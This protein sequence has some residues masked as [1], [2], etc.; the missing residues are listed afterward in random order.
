MGNAAVALS[1]LGFAVGMVFRFW[2]LLPILALLLLVSLVFSLVS[3]F[4]FFDTTLTIVAAQAIVQGS[5][6]LGLLIRALFS[7]AYRIKPIL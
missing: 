2:I 5:Y 7:A 6:F 1:I 3:G 4:T